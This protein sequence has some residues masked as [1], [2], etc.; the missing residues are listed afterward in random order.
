[1]SEWIKCSEQLPEFD[2][3]VLLIWDDQAIIG[4]LTKG[5]EDWEPEIFWRTLYFYEGKYCNET[6][7]LDGISHWMSKPEPPKDNAADCVLEFIEKY[8]NEDDQKTKPS[9]E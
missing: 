7:S 2:Q 1:M 8:A 3:E 9:P 4:I 5:K 6:E